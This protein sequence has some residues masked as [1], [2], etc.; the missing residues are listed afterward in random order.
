MAITAKSVVGGGR[1]IF[2]R[3]AGLVAGNSL[4]MER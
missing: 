3:K 4:E 2:A 1:E